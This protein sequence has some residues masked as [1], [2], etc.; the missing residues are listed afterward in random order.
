MIA[1]MSSLDS[2]RLRTGRLSE[3]EWALF[4]GFIE[5]FEHR[6]IRI[7]DTTP[8]SLM[9]LRAKCIQRKTMNKLDLVLVDYAGLLDGIGK[10]EYEQHSYLSRGLKLLAREL[11]VPIMAIHQFNRKGS[12]YERPSMF[13]LRGSGTWEQDADTVI[14]IYEPKDAVTGSKFAPR[15]V[16]IAKQRNGPKGFFNLIMNLSTTKFENASAGERIL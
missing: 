3:Q 7:D 13:H 15:T 14:L 8:L 5:D 1:Q 6:K 2:Q 11:N 16:E 12:E 10:T 9:T 4:T